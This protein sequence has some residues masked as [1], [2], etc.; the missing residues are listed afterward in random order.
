LTATFAAVDWIMSLE[1]HWF[2]TIYGVWFIVGQVLA[3][4]AL[5]VIMLR[6]LSSQAPFAGTVTPQHFHDLGN[7]MLAFTMLW[8]YVSFSQFLIIWSGNLPEEI[9]WYL[10]RLG[11]G[12]Q[13][14]ALFLVLFHFAV[15]FVLLLLRD[16]KTKMQRIAALAGFMLAMRLVDLFWVIMPAFGN[17]AGG[18]GPHLHW[19]DVTAPVG[20]GGVWIA[21]FAWQLKSRPL[22]PVH[23]PQGEAGF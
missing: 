11:S 1:P 10:Q 7:L 22:L 4:L 17:H 9:P 14:I 16:V 3:T 6:A 2:S 13:A 12:W 21:F 8:A 20:V 19:L 15:P 23:N 5:M 18:S